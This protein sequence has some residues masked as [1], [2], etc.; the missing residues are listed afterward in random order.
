MAE[1][2]QD[3]RERGIIDADEEMQGKSDDEFE[4]LDDLDEE[5]EEDIDEQ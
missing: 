5:Q 2:L 1:E 4:D 3:D